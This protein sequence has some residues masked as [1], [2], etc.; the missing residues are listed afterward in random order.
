V[1]SQ[2]E[3][4]VQPDFSISCSRLAV[5]QQ[6]LTGYVLGLMGFF[7]V[8]LLLLVIALCI[9]DLIRRLSTTGGAGKQMEN[10]EAKR[11]NIV[12]GNTLPGDQQK[13]G[14]GIQSDESGFVP[15][16]PG[17]KSSESHR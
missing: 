3:E 9:R 6:L 4:V 12:S 10:L 5:D 1:F 2:A 7:A 8:C 16:R 15:E 14:F 17:R 13:S 11:T